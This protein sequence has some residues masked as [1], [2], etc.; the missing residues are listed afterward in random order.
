MPVITGIFLVLFLLVPGVSADGGISTPATIDSS[1]TWYLQNDIVTAVDPC[2]RITASDVVFDGMGHR[3]ENTYLGSGSGILVLGSNVTMKNVTVA[4]WVEGIGYWNA[5]YGSITQVTATGNNRGIYLMNSSDSSITDSTISSNWNGNGIEIVSSNITVTGNHLEGNNNGIS[6][7][8]YTASYTGSRIW[9]NYFNN[10]HNVDYFDSNEVWNT[11]LTAGTNI[12]GGS[13]IGGNYW[14]QPDGNGF[15]QT[16]GDSDNDGICDDANGADQL[17]LHAPPES[18]DITG[19]GYITSP[20]TYYLRNDI[21]TAT[22]PAIPIVCGDVVFDGMGHRIEAGN[23]GSGTGIQVSKPNVTVK[24]VTVTGWS[25]G[26][27]YTNAPDGSITNTTVSSNSYGINIQSSGDTIT[28]NRLTG[29]SYGVFFN[30]GL[31]WV[32][33]SNHIFNNYFNNSNNV[34]GLD[35]NNIWNTTQTAGT[36]II[37]GSLIGGNYWA[38]PDG[39]GFSETDWDS[40]ND[41]ICNNAYGPDQLPLHVVVAPARW[42]R[43]GGTVSTGEDGLDITGSMGANTTLAW[44]PAGVDITSTSPATTISISSTVHNLAVS[45]AEFSNMTGT[46]YSYAGSSGGSP[47]PAFRVVNPVVDIAIRDIT[48]GNLNVTGKTAPVGDELG[49]AITNNIGNITVERNITPIPFDILLSGP[50][51]GNI[52]T[53]V[54]KNGI[55]SSLPNITFPVSPYSTGGIWNTGNTLYRT[56]IYTVR[57][58]AETTLNGMRGTSVN[59]TVIL[60]N[61]PAVVLPAPVIASVPTV[62]AYR[63][64]T[65]P[66]TILGSNF[67]PGTGNTTVEFR[68][69]S[70]G[71]IPTTL[72]NVTS[73]RIDGTIAIPNNVNTGSWNVRVITADGGENTKI[74]VFSIVNIS[75][76]A[77]TAVTPAT[78]WYRNATVPFLITGTNFQP[79]KTTISFNYPSNSTALN[80][81]DG[82]TVNTITATTINGTVVVPYNAPTG[83]WNVSVTT[84]DGGT[85]WKPSA[86]TVSRFPAPTILS[87][88]PVSGFRNT[89]VSYTI[90]GTNFMPGQTTVVLSNTSSGELASTVYSVTSTRITGAFEIPSTIP[91]GAW[92]LNVST[93]DGGLASK[94]SA[95]TVNKLPVPAIT[96]FTPSTAY[97]GTPVSFVINGNNFQ[98]GGLTTVNLTKAGQ[99]DIQTTL[100]S[101]F[102]TQITGTVTIP[103]DNT[104]GSWK[105]NVTTV[106]GGV[107]T[108]LNAIAVL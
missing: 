43:P 98:P 16:H 56:G 30:N 99:T 101:V 88:S 95:F 15:S 103:S 63:N 78:A 83:A 52:P 53:L 96:S 24:N 26:I 55:V 59:R 62:S 80:S 36:N 8:S 79:G 64:S 108:K 76:P 10:T 12:I 107:G 102:P 89:T 72:T 17:P 47:L 21:T 37:G 49:F 18:Y 87:I 100:T 6:F 44:W 40:G 104:T 71:V 69:Q 1:G 50:D 31:T 42:V 105:V 4:N 70:S 32:Y 93:L 23:A 20:G 39:T 54:S 5:P 33:T 65:V 22:T 97:R 29:N 86:F 74:N 46:W 92:R 38:Q 2:I 14:A 73:I 34:Y 106:D 94:P 57:V 90:T 13:L 45:P 48:T 75:R 60:S 9:N 51:G 77:I 84:L 82:F 58:E 61:T 7:S 81:T 27:Y 28:G 41:G 3:I 66:F 68:N 25:S 67:E 35:G 85:I 91:T 19:P 11:T